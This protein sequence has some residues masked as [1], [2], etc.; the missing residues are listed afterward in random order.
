M[1]V[2]VTCEQTGLCPLF[3][4]DEHAQVGHEVVRAVG[5]VYDL[6]RLFDFYMTGHIEKESVLHESRVECHGAVFPGASQAAVVAVDQV[7]VA[8]GCFAEAASQYALGQ[9]LGVVA[10][11]YVADEEVGLAFEVGNGT[12]ETLFYC[13]LRGD[14]CQVEPVVGRIEG[15]DV[16]VQELLLPLMGQTQPFEV[17][18][19]GIASAVQYGSRV[20]V[21]E[22]PVLAVEVDILLC[23]IHR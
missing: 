19:G 18:H 22:F 15:F 10:R 5:E 2:V 23:G 8:G 12:S 4:H 13:G 16:G 11:E 9:G 3:E 6:Q 1:N 17:A 7:G 21:D 14:A 20:A